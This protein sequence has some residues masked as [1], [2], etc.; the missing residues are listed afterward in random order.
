MCKRVVA[1]TLAD[2]DRNR[3]RA[4]AAGLKR[5]HEK[6]L[7]FGSR[8]IATL[9]ADGLV[10]LYDLDRKGSLSEEEALL[11]M[12]DIEKYYQPDDTRRINAVMDYITSIQLP[13]C[14]SSLETLQARE[15]V[16]AGAPASAAPAAHHGV[17][18]I[19]DHVHL[20]PRL[21]KLVD[22]RKKASGNRGSSK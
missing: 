17:S 14:A 8:A 2:A 11:M 6:R 19:L 18:R 9:D 7:L 3:S 22:A 4:A 1:D 15:G 12:A 16:G 21:A 10:Q 5:S 20:P 13:Q